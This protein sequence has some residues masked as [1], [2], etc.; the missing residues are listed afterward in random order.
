ML[1]VGRNGANYGVLQSFQRHTQA[2]TVLN[3]SCELSVSVHVAAVQYGGPATVYLQLS[4]EL[5]RNV[6]LHVAA[7]V[8]GLSLVH[9][10]SAHWTTKGCSFLG[11]RC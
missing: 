11:E 4:A 5:G 8:V 9:M 6:D 1:P 10:Q 3:P 2:L 7:K